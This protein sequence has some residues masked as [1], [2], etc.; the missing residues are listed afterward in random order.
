MTDS[1]LRKSA[2]T[3]F[4]WGLFLVALLMLTV[5]SIPA[6][7]WH[8]PVNDAVYKGFDRSL[9]YV[10]ESGKAPAKGVVEVLADSLTLTALP[11]S[12]PTVHLATT[13]LP[14]FRAAM[15]VRTLES[16][17]GTTP[18]RI[19]IWTPRGNYGVFV[20][21]D[22]SLITVQTMSSGQVV[23]AE[24][25]GPY[26]P[27]QLYW[28]ELSLNKKT[29]TI[30]S[31]IID[32]SEVSPS[33]GPA[34]R[35][36]GKAI[37]QWYSQVYSTAVP[38]EGGKEYSFGGA[39]KL[40]RGTEPYGFV[41]EWQDNRR[42]LLGKSEEWHQVRELAGWTAREYRARAPVGAHFAVLALGTAPGTDM[43]FADPFLKD[44]QN[45]LVNLLPN[46]DFREGA[47]GW[48][49]GTLEPIPLELLDTAPVHYESV[50]SYK[51]LPELFDELRLSLTMNAASAAGISSAVVENYV[52][53]LPHQRWLTSRIDDS[54]TKALVIVL[55][56]LGGLLSLSR[57]VVWT[58]P[59]V[60]K[61]N[62]LPQA[63]WLRAR[64]RD[65]LT[66]AQSPVWM[67]ATVGALVYLLLNAL[68]FNAGSLNYDLL[69]GT[70]W[71][72][73][74]ARYGLSELYHLPAVTAVPEAWAGAPLQ[75]AAF[76]YLPIMAYLFLLVG[77][78]YKIFLA[79]PGALTRNAFQL[80]F[81]IKSFS[82]LFAYGS[83]ILIYLILREQKVSVRWSLLAAGFFLLN[84][85]VWFIGSVWGQTQSWS[86][87]FLLLAIWFGEKRFPLLA[88]LALAA[89]ALTR[90]QML[91]PAAL[92]ALVFLRR[93]SIKENL[94]AIAWSVVLVF[95][96][97]A[98]FSLKIGPS[99]S[100]DVVAKSFGVNYEASN[101]RWTTLVS[102]S[103]L[104]LWP[105]VT[106]IA[107]GQTGLNRIFYSSKERLVGELAYWQVGNLL[108][109]AL[110][111]AAAALVLLRQSS[112]T[113]SSSYIPIIALGTLGLFMLKTEF[114]AFHVLPA[115]ALVIL[116]RR[117][118][119]NF[120]YCTIVAILTITIFVP[121][122]SIA[123]VWQS[124]NPPLSIGL[125][126]P[127]NPIT[128]FFKGL[129]AQDLFITLGSLANVLVLVW[130][131]IVSVR[132]F[133]RASTTSQPDW[134]PGS[135]G[136][137]K[138][139]HRAPS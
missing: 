126:D 119:N 104:S 67:T 72:Y 74:L 123:G 92:L 105:L 106:L 4:T 88:W 118:M 102:W 29:G 46:G 100:V 40:L 79:D 120:A 52:L 134:S 34:L 91:V 138:P 60:G 57:V 26:S 55:L 77:W 51:D 43:L 82:A 130:L 80:A 49:R 5:M 58:W 9:I 70:V 101:D 125:F 10:D 35:V 23:K 42:M 63:N 108:F 78:I 122:Y 19:G 14:K 59:K 54:R 7:F 83:A 111:V 32:A 37:P 136:E 11:N 18:F 20:V 90:Q 116:S 98:P 69:G 112:A 121:M 25:L 53:I 44:S 99:L 17:E 95:L 30:Y 27:G 85:A 28:L 71:G 62:S 139:G 24:I 36:V 87:F 75:E 12:Q 129:I 50:V 2:R 33:G 131:G 114:A 45:L 61:S 97:L 86:I 47:K 93:F 16:Q 103:A 135:T 48:R 65:L 66:R 13:P 15:N 41:V 128:R 84:P 113:R 21:F 31:R 8:Q 73:S 115:L 96:L 107:D 132:P 133:L 89:T 56:V 38:V 1:P 117:S 81:V 3:P 76:P 124:Y 6:E 127:A 109:G 64:L 39:V 137:A 22:S 68:L 94:Q 110:F